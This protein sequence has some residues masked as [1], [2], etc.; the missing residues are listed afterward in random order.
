MP[1]S[2]DDLSKNF[3]ERMER[4]SKPVIEEID[5]ALHMSY[6]PGGDFE[7]CFSTEL[8]E[9]LRSHV[10]TVYENNGWIVAWTTEKR[11]ISDYQDPKPYSVTVSK[12]GL[13]PNPHRDR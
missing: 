2:P 13:S 5:N 7:Y 1:Y 10:T 9:A 6:A 3:Y 11:S 12:I 4:L 8:S